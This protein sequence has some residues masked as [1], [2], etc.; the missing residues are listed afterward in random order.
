MNLY[1]VVK[2]IDEIISDVDEDGVIQNVER[3]NQ[4][5][6]LFEVKAGNIAGGMKNIQLDENMVDAQ[7]AVLEKE[8]ESLRVKRNSL[9]NRRRRLGEFLMDTMHKMGLRKLKA[10]GLSISIVRG[11]A[12]VDVV[13]EDSIDEKFLHRFVK[14]RK[15]DIIEHWKRTEETPAGAKIVRRPFVRI[16]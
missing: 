11:R 13:N 12:S 2:E 3:L 9:Q 6:M 10:C 15:L 16:T 14:V 8:A 1:D 4:L 5:D 7:I